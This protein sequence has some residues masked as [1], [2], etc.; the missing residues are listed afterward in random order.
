V[1]ANI[2]A[3]NAVIHL[4]DGVLTV[5][6]DGNGAY[7][8]AAPSDL[9]ETEGASPTRFTLQWTPPQECT[10]SSGGCTYALEQSE[11]LAGVAVADATWTTLLSSA[12]T[13]LLVTVRS[14][15]VLFRYRV[16]AALSGARGTQ[17]SDYRFVCNHN[18][19]E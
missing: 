19:H 6:D 12:A 4:I 13:S 1:Q 7:S 8:F 9:R 17:L 2:V 11:V 18:W 16:R 5:G 10:S 14:S 15:T 3:A